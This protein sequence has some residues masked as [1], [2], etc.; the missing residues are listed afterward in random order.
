MN[1]DWND[2]KWA[3]YGKHRLRFRLWLEERRLKKQK[4][5]VEQ[6]RKELMLYCIKHNLTED[7]FLEFVKRAF[8]DPTHPVHPQAAAFIDLLFDEAY[9]DLECRLL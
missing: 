2:I 6:L 1:N 3:L 8:A 5:T 9:Y 7:G 4:P